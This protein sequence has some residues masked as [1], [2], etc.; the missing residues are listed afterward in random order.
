MAASS[1]G[2]LPSATGLRDAA[3]RHAGSRALSQATAPQRLPFSQPKASAFPPSHM[4]SRTSMLDS[5]PAAH[6]YG[7]L[8]LTPLTPPP[9]SSG[10]IRMHRFTLGI[11]IAVGLIPAAHA[12]STP[13]AFDICA[14]EQDSA[15]RLA[16]FDRQVAARHA[17]NPP[18]PAA[19]RAD[20]PTSSAA[21][22]TP[23]VLA[24]PAPVPAAGPAPAP[25]SAA[26]SASDVGL[27]ARQIRKLHPERAESGK[28]GISF[29]AKVVRVIARRP[30]ISAFELDNGQIWEQSEV[31]D[32]LWV[33]P[34]EN[35]TIRAGAM[36]G[37]M[38]KSADGHLV[39][40]WRVR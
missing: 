33:R 22:T 21:A 34:A 27:D 20:A 23:K 11:V 4:N 38:L 8:D 2:L 24:A 6:A 1:L 19:R 3:C 15:A 13:D 18:P 40:V 37:F 28:G 7:L 30:L 17:T 9:H 12:Q 16:C 5:W 31:V 25:A 36:G 39:H 10:S 14:R 29:D 32:G 35:V 26:S